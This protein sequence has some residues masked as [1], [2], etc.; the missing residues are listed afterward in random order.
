MGCG[1]RAERGDGRAGWQG[2]G[3]GIWELNLGSQ[4]SPQAGRP[5]TCSYE[6]SGL[7]LSCGS[8]PELGPG[9]ASTILN[10][11]LLTCEL[12]IF[13]MCYGEISI[14]SVCMDSCIFLC[15]ELV[16]GIAFFTDV[17]ID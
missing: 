15:K 14:T 6:W 10:P 9:P 5:L 7:Y 2:S 17:W 8:L 11:I 16:L 12:F 3:L 1:H 13:L 4:G